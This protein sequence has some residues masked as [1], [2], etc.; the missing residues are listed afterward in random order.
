M[1]TGVDLDH[2]LAHQYFSDSQVH[3]SECGRL[4]G[5]VS[6][7]CRDQKSGARRIRHSS[8]RGCMVVWSVAAWLSAWLTDDVPL[9]KVDLSPSN[10]T[11]VDRFHFF[12]SLLA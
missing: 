4:R 5:I 9:S 1:Q 10:A 7:G 6:H 8:L 2:D 3:G 12:M 11:R